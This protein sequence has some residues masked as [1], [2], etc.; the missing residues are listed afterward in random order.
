MVADM[1][2]G[3]GEAWR[4]RKYWTKGEGLAKWATSPHPWTTLRTLLSKHM[5]PTQ[6]AGLAS[7][8]FKDVFGIWPGERKGKNPVGPG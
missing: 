4:L 8:Y 6:A 3:D 5:S 1:N 7:S 2:P